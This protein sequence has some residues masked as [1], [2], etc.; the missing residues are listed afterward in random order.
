MKI[1]GYPLDASYRH[2]QCFECIRLLGFLFVQIEIAIAIGIVFIT[3]VNC[4]L[5]ANSAATS[6]IFNRHYR[7]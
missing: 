2:I 5:L 7:E 4:R 3:S 1:Y 6:A